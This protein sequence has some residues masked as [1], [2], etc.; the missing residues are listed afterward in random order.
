VADEIFKLMLPK[1][2]PIAPAAANPSLIPAEL[3][4][5]WNGKL[6][7]YKAELPF[8]LKV[9]ESG[10][11][12]ARIGTQLQMLVNDARWENGFLVGR[13]LSDIRTED[14]NRR[15]YSLLL[16]LK[17]RGA[18]LNGPVSAIS[19]PGKRAGNALT[20]WAELRR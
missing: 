19:L 6:V 18:V 16:T 20:S 2:Q 11:V 17:P 13:F 9:N 7:T 12:L 10:Q 8:E 1:W 5:T 14:A 4:G 3:F 15:P